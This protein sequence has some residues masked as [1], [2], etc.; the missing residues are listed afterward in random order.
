MLDSRKCNSNKKWNN[1]QYQYECKN[2]KELHVYKKKKTKKYIQNL[3][4]T[5]PTNFN[6]KKVTC[7]A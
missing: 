7:T 2:R 1:D 4:K 3:G 6:G 5:F